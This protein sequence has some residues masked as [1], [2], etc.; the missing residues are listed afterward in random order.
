MRFQICSLLVLS[1]SFASSVANAQPTVE[2]RWRS[3]TGSGTPGTDTITAE[4]GDYL[5]LDILVRSNGPGL[6]AAE[7]S[8]YWDGEI[9]TGFDPMVCPTPENPLGTTFC[10]VNPLFL[11]LSGVVA[12]PGWAETFSAYNTSAEP[13]YT[14]FTPMYLGRITLEVT[15][16][17]PADIAAGYD[18][19]TEGIRDGDGNVSFPE[20][21]ASVLPPPPGC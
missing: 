15:N 4:V 21:T 3:T 18:P 19:E 11:N 12:G 16:S 13:G 17:A 6:N 5:E 1:V 8:L 14:G 9:L 7:V 2:L 10:G 20:A